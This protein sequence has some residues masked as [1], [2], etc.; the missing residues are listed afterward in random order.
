M[1]RFTFAQAKEKIK[2]LE[3]KIEDL[4]GILKDEFENAKDDIVDDVKNWG[5]GDCAIAL[6]GF[7]LGL[8]IGGIF[9]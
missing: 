1:A 4:E 5:W 7:L 8:L 6:G 2:E 9:I 3:A